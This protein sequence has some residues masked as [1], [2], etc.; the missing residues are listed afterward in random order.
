M[1]TTVSTAIALTLGSQSALSLNTQPEPTHTA[2]HNESQT[3][4]VEL[5]QKSSV[6]SGTKNVLE[7]QDSVIS[8][9][10]LQPFTLLFFFAM[11]GLGGFFKLKIVHTKLKHNSEDS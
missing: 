2:T 10:V 3:T 8:M 9:P 4:P 5:I 1:I 6:V 7:V 11:A